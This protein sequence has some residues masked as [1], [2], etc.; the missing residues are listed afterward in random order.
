MAGKQ[1]GVTTLL[2]T[3]LLLTLTLLIILTSYRSTLFHIKQVNNELMA[4]Q[5]HWIAEGGLECLYAQIMKEQVI[6]AEESLSRCNLP[7]GLTM[8]IAPNG[9]RNTDIEAKHGFARLNRQMTTRL[10]YTGAI[11]AS[12]NLYMR[13]ALNASTPDPGQKTSGGWQ[14]SVLRYKNQFISYAHPV[15]S[16][17]ATSPSPGGGFNNPD[18]KNCLPSH[19]T[20]GRGEDWLRDTSVEPFQVLFGVPRQEHD[21]IRD[22]KVDGKQVFTVLEG[23]VNPTGYKKLN[24]C[25]TAILNAAEAGSRHIWIEGGCELDQL[26]LSELA[27]V[28]EQGDDSSAKAITLVVHDGLLSLNAAA[29]FRGVLIH[30]NQDYSPKEE[31]WKSHAS[32]YPHLFHIPSLWGTDNARRASY[33]QHGSFD[34]TGA[35]FLDSPDQWVVTNDS[36][37]IKF[38][39]DV[40]EHT[41]AAFQRRYRWVAGS[42]HDF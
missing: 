38:N 17:V 24:N 10:E 25:G 2:V 33:Y 15:N 22:K 41:R 35:M 5:S 4:R 37:N 36:M 31:D 8:A 1:Y 11:Q 32:V 40:L 13:G 16:G 9:Y 42:W 39:Q 20:Y 27:T 23:V 12:A 7:S 14:C 34:I 28:I 3:G 18:H 19:M 29:S 30:F 6:P 26:S 21:R